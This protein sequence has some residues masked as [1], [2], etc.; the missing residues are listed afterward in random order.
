M[1]RHRGCHVLIEGDPVVDGAGRELEAEGEPGVQIFL[2]VQPEPVAL[3]EVTNRRCGDVPLARD[4]VGSE[5]K[6][7]AQTEPGR[8]QGL[9]R[10]LGWKTRSGSV[11][12]RLRGRAGASRDT[13][14]F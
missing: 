13:P 7:A 8:F 2:H 14:A 6:V 9:L 10:L 4:E 3:T 11:A 1:M 5:S 12:R